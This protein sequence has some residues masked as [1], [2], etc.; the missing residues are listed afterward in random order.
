MKKYLSILVMLF[1]LFSLSVIAADK[2]GTS[3][4]AKWKGDKACAMILMFDDSSSTHVKTVFPE[5]QKRGFTGTFYVNPGA[6]HYGANRKVWEKVIPEAGF[7]LAN[8]TLTHKGGMSKADIEHEVTGC[9][10]A[11]RK[12]T[13]GLPW[14]RLISYGQPGGIKKENWPVSKEELAVVLKKNNLIDRPNFGSRGA[15]IALKTGE[16]MLAHV[17]KAVKNGVMECIIF[18]GV[19]GDW[20]SV[21]VKEFITLLD[22]LTQRKDKVWVTQ[23]M[24][25]HKYA[26]ERDSAAVKTVK[27]S[28]N[29]ITLQLTAKTDPK[30]YDES[31]TLKTTVPSNWK[32][33]TVKQGNYSAELQVE[34]S[35]VMYDALPGKDLITLTKK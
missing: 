3:T 29:Q 20:I 12:S 15:A 19:G 10:E 34:N 35:L 23:H 32:K 22:G 6:G 16:Q 26:A 9:N 17:D 18:H 13:P 21:P 25:A 8:H 7:E 27:V 33:C 11:I 31:L 14:P 1:L 5:L 4:V 2:P 30:F 28:A 24:A